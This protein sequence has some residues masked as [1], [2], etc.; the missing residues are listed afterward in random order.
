[1]IL[2]GLRETKLDE[3]F[4]ELLDTLI[5]LSPQLLQV[6]SISSAKLIPQSISNGVS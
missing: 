5:W 6:L 4:L 2:K 1:M 3:R